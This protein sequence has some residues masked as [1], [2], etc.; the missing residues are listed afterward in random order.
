MEIK[1]KQYDTTITWEEASDDITS[2]ELLSTFVNLMY[3]LGYHPDS[4][5]RSI[6]ELAEDYEDRS[7]E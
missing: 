4:V 1:I 2:D 5:I 3:A 6:L 7:S